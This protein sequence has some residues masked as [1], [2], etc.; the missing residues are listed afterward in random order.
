[1]TCICSNKENS[2][3]DYVSLVNSIVVTKILF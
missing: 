1:M 2:D 3:I